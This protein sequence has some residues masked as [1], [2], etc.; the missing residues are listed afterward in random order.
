MN[1]RASK[2]C[3]DTEFVARG[4]RLR[5]LASA[6]GLVVAIAVVATVILVVIADWTWEDALGTAIPGVIIGALAV[7][8]FSVTGRRRAS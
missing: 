5:S 7:L 6:L 8:L 2:G 4:S 1:C 3:Y